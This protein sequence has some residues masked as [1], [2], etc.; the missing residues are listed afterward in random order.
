MYVSYKAVI[1]ALDD[2]YG[3]LITTSDHDKLVRIITRGI[4][5][6]G[7]VEAFNL[8]T[9]YKVEI[10]DGIGQL[11]CFLYRLLRTTSKSFNN[12]FT[13]NVEGNYLKPSFMNGTLYI[14]YYELPWREE[15]G[16]K[17]PLIKNYLV[18]YLVAHCV[19][20]L[21]KPKFLSSEI[22][23]AQWAEIKETFHGLLSDNSNAF[24]INNSMDD[25][26]QALFLQRNSMFFSPQMYNQ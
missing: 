7:D 2:E 20:V 14:D 4:L 8:V 5:A 3:S 10:H 1:S 22:N 25:L 23:Q 18:E 19:K 15:G 16:K 11:P 12:N 9:N 21:F 17:V 26:E 13:V 24:A 6:K